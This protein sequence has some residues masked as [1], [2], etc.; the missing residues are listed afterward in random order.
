MCFVVK[1]MTSNFAFL[2][3]TWPKL[4]R[5]AEFAEQNLYHDP[6]T[7]LSKLRLF[8]EN[9]TIHL[10]DYLNL[11]L[12]ADNTQFE[13]LKILRN[14]GVLPPEV[15]MIFHKLRK[16]GNDAIHAGFDSFDEAKICLSFAHKLA[17]WFAVV[18]DNQPEAAQFEFT[19]PERRDPSAEFEQLKAEYEK[20]AQELDRLK[21]ERLSAEKQDERKVLSFAAAQQLKFDEAETRKL[22]DAQLRDAGWEADTKRLKWP[23][24][25]PEPGKN[26]AIAEW[27]VGEQNRADY[28][29]FIGLQFVGIIEAKKKQKDVSSDIGQAQ[30]YAKL[31]LIHG[32]EQ[33]TGGP[34]CGHRVPF[35]FASNGRGFSEMVKSKSGLWF[36]DLRKASNHAKALRNWYSPDD[37]RDLLRRDI[38]QGNVHLKQESFAYLQSPNGANLRDYQIAAI[39]AVEE[40]ILSGRDR[41]LLSMA[42]GTGKT[43]TALGLIYRLLKSKRFKRILFV[44]D[45]TSL[46]DQAE[47]IFKETRLEELQ[48][49]TEIYDVKGLKD[50]TPDEETKLH[51]A[52]VQ[53]LVRRVSDPAVAPSVGQYDCVIVDEAH[54]GYLLDREGGGDEEFLSQKDYLS[55]YRNAIEY[56]EATRIGLTATPAFHT[57][58]IFGEPAY[59]YGYRQAVIDGY[60]VDFE[61]PYQID[62]ALKL[63][64]I[65]YV[66]DR[67]ALIYNRRTAAIEEIAHLE[68]DVD[69]EIDGFN[70]KVITPPF[71]QAVAGELIKH[72][73]PLDDGK[74]LI[75]AASD[76]HAD[77]VVTTLKDAYQAAGRAVPDEAILK[78]TGSVENQLELIRHFKNE[79]FPNIVVTVDLLTTGIDVPKITNLVFLRRVKSRILYEQMLG[80]ATRRCDEIGKDHFSIYDAVGLYDVLEP[81]SAMKPVAASISERFVE[82]ITQMRVAASP[83]E[84]QAIRD[85]ILAKLQ[86]KKQRIIKAEQRLQELFLLKSNNRT[87]EQYIKELAATPF[88]K[89]LGRLQAD[90]GLFELLDH[91]SFEPNFQYVSTAPDQVVSVTR[92][93]GK[94]N[95]APED[96]LDTF[97]RYLDEQKD[98]IAALSILCQRPATLTRNDVKQLRLILEEAGFSQTHLNDAWN[99]VTHD[100]IL[101]DMITLIRHLALGDA[102][103]SHQERI[104]R[105]VGKIRAM[106]AWTKVQKQWLDRIEKQL[107]VQD[108]IGKE[109]FDA[110]PFASHGG[111][112]YI[113]NI[114][115]G[116]LA[117]ML[118]ALNEY[119]YQTA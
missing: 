85:K 13:R 15:D 55:K 103:V 42:T 81:V 91:E 34:W 118:D 19:M 14:R 102:L 94:N 24:C 53:S 104:S 71:N 46:G 22:I 87:P 45:R 58:D 9:I 101:I 106:K 74:T 52:T 83:Q 113:N 7:T 32:E 63:A 114:F 73:D 47:G 10:F 111:F 3:N 75:F 49:L 30:K 80:R 95:A 84:M 35:V 97:K 37:L 23:D 68:D 60:L 79:R 12:P 56:F 77:L 27:P 57:I 11:P 105:A 67:P 92:G 93:Y 76:E 88:A 98:R 41:V 78:I 43:R 115:D 33:F 100:E 2:A 4:A 66:K 89:L 90:W 61:P 51:I 110:E 82:L 117:T 36:L 50:A 96:Y 44:V 54:R 116:E 40:A 17:R 1:E 108:P 18:Y 119:L 112:H 64:G 6:N 65:H 38:E 48:T 86:R 39:K 29:L 28:A 109:D 20:T 21:T 16:F 31:A 70:T 99:A 72:V 8:S 107:L 25:I 62:T 5:H 26:R 69:I 59:I